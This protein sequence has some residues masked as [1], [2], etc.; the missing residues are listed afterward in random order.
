MTEYEGLPRAVPEDMGIS[1]A[2]LERIKPVMQQWVDNG[3]IP[4]ALTMIA[5]EGKLVHFEKFGKQDVATA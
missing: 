5:R 4:G 2:R 1:T 3:K